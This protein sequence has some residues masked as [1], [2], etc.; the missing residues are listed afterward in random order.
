MTEPGFS[1]AQPL[2]LEESAEPE[3]REIAGKQPCQY[4]NM[5]CHEEL[6][7]SDEEGLPCGTCAMLLA[8]PDVGL[9]LSHF[10]L[11]PSQKIAVARTYANYLA[12][13]MPRKSKR[14]RDEDE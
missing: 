3:L 8:S 2:S 7:P 13:Q 5:M 4:L 12:A 11:E 1:H 6:E 10:V 14:T 9:Y